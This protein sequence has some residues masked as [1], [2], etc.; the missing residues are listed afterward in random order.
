M[1]RIILL[2]LLILPQTVK[3]NQIQRF[4]KLEQQIAIWA[5]PIA[6]AESNLRQ[7]NSKNDVGIFQFHI[8]TNKIYGFDRKK[9]ETDIVYQY[10]CYQKV[11]R[12]KYRICYRKYPVSWVACFHSATPRYHWKYWKNIKRIK[13]SL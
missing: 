4:L 12:D 11:M 6:I 1:K 9:L 8:T 13:E 3:A 5:L 2:M 10:E 7:I